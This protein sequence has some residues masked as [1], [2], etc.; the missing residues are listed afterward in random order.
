[1]KVAFVSCVKTKADGICRAGE[2]YTSPW[3]KMAR[4]WAERNADQ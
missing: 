3:F 1:M 2:M 4:F